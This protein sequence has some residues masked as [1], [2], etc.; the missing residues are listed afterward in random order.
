[1]KIREAENYIAA[2]LECIY[3]ANEAGNIS[4]LVIEHITG[5]LPAAMNT[6]KDE[7]H[8]TLS[9]A[10]IDP[11]IKRLLNHEPIQYIMNKTWFYGLEL[12]IDASVLIPRPE[13]EELAD[14]VIKDIKKSG[15]DVF[16]RNPLRADETSRLK[17]M[18]I[19]TGSGC[20]ALALKKAIPLAEVWGCDISEAALNI[21]RRNGSQLDIRVDFQ[22][23]NFLD[24][25][26]QKLL[27][28]VDVVVCNPP[29]IPV[30]DRQTMQ[31][32]VLQF[33]PHVALF[34]PDEDP[35]VFYKALA[36]YGSHRL[37]DKGCIYMEIH[38]SLAA[39][40]MSIFTK[41]YE[42]EVRRDMQGKER[43]VKAKRRM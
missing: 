25:G 13:T 4:K 43:M 14:W 5:L 1:M 7:D 17:I 20:I 24:A 18:D 38:E 26:Q 37:H 39:G 15:L 21:A 12:F 41:D 28:S 27:P 30:K 29:Y 2:K 10:A 22:G 23:M 3:P 40:V 11:F 6:R 8:G 19:C 34:V 16:S 42:V 33:E 35:L 32:N 31:P 9:L 36:Y